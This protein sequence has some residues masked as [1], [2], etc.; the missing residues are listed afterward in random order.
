MF[1]SEKLII[2]EGKG[3]PSSVV[4]CSFS[5]TTQHNSYRVL[6]LAS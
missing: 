3:A 5:A 6:F 4:L 1:M 2:F